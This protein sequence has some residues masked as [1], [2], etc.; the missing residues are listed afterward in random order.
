MR[1]PNRL[2]RCHPSSPCSGGRP[3]YRPLQL[4][5]LPSARVG[6][7][8]IQCKYP[9]SV[10]GEALKKSA[11]KARP[12]G[13]GRHD[14]WVFS[15]RPPPNVRRQ[16]PRAA[17]RRGEASRAFEVDSWKR[18]DE[19]PKELVTLPGETF[20][21]SALVDACSAY[22]LHQSQ[23]RSNRYRQGVFFSV[24]LGYLDIAAPAR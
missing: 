3:S 13:C 11:A 19:F 8:E 1:N 2:P 14:L 18:Q 12:D 16:N 9:Q 23:P 17:R 6:R 5:G 21:S 15:G 22:C 10:E 20:P 24:F 4:R 7:K